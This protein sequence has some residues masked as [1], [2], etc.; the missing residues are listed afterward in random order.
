MCVLLA[1][2]KKEKEKKNVSNEKSKSFVHR[3]L[4]GESEVLGARSG[5]LFEIL[6]ADGQIVRA[7]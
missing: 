7:R 5:S 3:R 6:V 1:I 4:A 2:K